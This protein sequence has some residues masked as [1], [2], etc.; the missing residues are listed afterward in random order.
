ME[1]IEKGDKVKIK[2]EAKLESGEECFPEN[3]DDTIEIIIGEGKIFSS[4][5][6]CLKDMKTGETK[7]ITIEPNEA[8]GPYHEN[9]I[10]DAPR[11]SFKTDTDLSIGMRIKI[12]TPTEKVY[13]ATII[14]MTDSA[15]T[16]D[17][18]HPL[19]GKK[20]IFTV[21]VVDINKK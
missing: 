7:T 11:T 5:E 6:N 1:C 13:Y 21:T 3:N 17:L 10:I 9:L 8:F 14:K 4:I 2:Y 20:L 15:I 19:A 12:D 16:L 18:N